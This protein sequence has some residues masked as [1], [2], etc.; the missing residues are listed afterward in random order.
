[1]TYP[2][3]T[4]EARREANR[5]YREKNREKLRAYEAARYERR[6][7]ERKQKEPNPLEQEAARERARAWRE[8]N[9]ERHRESNAAWRRAH[10][11][12]GR[13]RMVGVPGAHSD[14]EWLD[15]VAY[16]KNACVYC[17]GGGK[18]TRDHVIP[19]SRKELSPTND[20]DNILPACQS[21]N[22]RKRN[23]TDWEYRRWLSVKGPVCLPSV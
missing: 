14:A 18:M 1:V 11:D 2:S 21:C 16:F 20:I 4:P 22:S 7:A 13:E 17:G 9:P 3:H 23:K 6:Y 19:I 8:A 12:Y 5:L 10:P 15:L